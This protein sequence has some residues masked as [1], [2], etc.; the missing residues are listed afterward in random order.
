MDMPEDWENEGFE[1]VDDWV[2][3]VRYCDTSCPHY[4][5]LNRCCWQA[6]RQG[7][8]FSVSEGE[9]CHL[10]YTNGDGK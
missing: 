8:C 5:E 3:E 4:D 10:G 1:S 7:L 2:D 6:T 9:V